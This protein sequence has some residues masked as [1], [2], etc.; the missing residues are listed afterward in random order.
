MSKI[1]T[2]TIFPVIFSIALG[3][4][5]ALIAQAQQTSDQLRLT[6]TLTATAR[7]SEQ[8]STST[9]Q[10]VGVVS[11]NKVS[12]IAVNNAKESSGAKN[13][14]TNPVEIY[15][16]GSGDVLDIRLVNASRNTSTLYTVL[17]GG[18]LEFPLIGAQPLNVNNLT[19]DEIAALLT[20]ELK[21]REVDFTPH[22]IVNVREFA[23]HIVL[24]NGLVESPGTHVLRR[25]AVPLYVVVA[26]AM[27][28]RNAGR[29]TLISRATNERRAFNF[30]DSSAMNTHVRAGDVLIIEERPHEFFYIAGDVNTPGEKDF[31]AGMT[32]TQAILAAGGAL[33]SKGGARVGRQGE[34]GRLSFVEYSLKEIEAG[35]VADPRLQSGDRIEVGKH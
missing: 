21:R 14:S 25:E 2:R 24:V 4:S 19:T 20:D 9:T 1:N 26:E 6:P 18:L 28:K 11:Q 32:L 3:V 23:S 22:F 33:H 10:T 27:P 17:A 31:R 5:A 30:A 16:I 12:A 34:D 7:G 15:R 35:N 8:G 13:V 29:V